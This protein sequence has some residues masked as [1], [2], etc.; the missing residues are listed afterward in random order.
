SGE[1]PRKDFLQL[2]NTGG[3]TPPSLRSPRPR[4]IQTIPKKNR[5]QWRDRTTGERQEKQR[6]GR[7]SHG[8]APRTL[9]P[10]PRRMGM[11][12]PG[13]DVPWA[14]QRPA[15]ESA[16]LAWAAPSQ[17]GPAPRRLRLARYAN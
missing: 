7:I 15:G 17:V 10:P 11:R 14:G 4:G 13:R 16:L 3:H 2:H 12:P 6:I 1:P 5:K 8:R 9:P